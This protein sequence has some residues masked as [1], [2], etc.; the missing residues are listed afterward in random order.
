MTP[1]IPDYIERLV[2]YEPGKPIEELERELGISGS[3]K[4]ASNENPVGPSPAVVEAIM[5]NAPKI[6]LYP[7]GDCF[8]LKAAL[9]AHL[10]VTRDHLIVGNGSNE[11]LE[12]VLRALL[13]PGDETVSAA[14]AFVV[15]DLSTR[16]MGGRAVQVPMKKHAHDLAAMARAVTDRTRVVFV[17]NPNN[18]TGTAVGAR[19][20]GR[21]LDDIPAEVM[22][23]VDEAYYEYVDLRSYPDT[24]KMVADGRDNL[25]VLRT[26]SKA[27]GLAG[28]RVGF[29]V[30]APPVVAAL[31]K[32]R[33][34]FNVNLLAQVA[35]L[36]ALA[37]QEHVRK[38]VSL[39]RRERRRLEKAFAAA[40]LEFVPSQ[41]NFILVRVGH[42]ARETYRSLLSRGVIVRP[43][44]GY[45][46][47]DWLRVTVGLPEENDRFLREL[48]DLTA[49][50]TS[51]KRRCRT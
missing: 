24:L 51:A 35:A 38:V 47:P 21:F 29:G 34:P 31:N 50:K 42:G 11:L 14:G 17:A 2:P 19:E 39:C 48:A 8:Y 40:S 16:A 25:V 27:Y 18:P 12:L 23:V 30:A 28:L 46:Y 44:G 13:Q 3:I 15:Y 5:Q 32:V 1:R 45:G 26:F 20:F 4:L 7:D 9:A 49:P 10:G 41:G 6:N 36:A 33:Q 22:V 43:M 37:D